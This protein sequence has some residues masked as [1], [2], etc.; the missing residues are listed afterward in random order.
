[1]GSDPEKIQELQETQELYD[2]MAELELLRKGKI[3]SVSWTKTQ[4]QGP[5]PA[6]RPKGKFPFSTNNTF[7][8]AD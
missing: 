1:M 5:K 2:M 4:G 3:K 6:P 8:R 7:E